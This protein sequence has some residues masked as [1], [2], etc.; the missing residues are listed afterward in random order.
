MAASPKVPSAEFLAL[1]EKYLAGEASPEELARWE[2][3][4]LAD[5]DALA[6]YVSL[7][8]IE[9][10][11]PKALERLEL[12]EPRPNVIPF[13]RRPAVAALAAC[14]A[15]GVL[16]GLTWIEASRH[17][18]PP[19]AISDVPARITS[20]VGVR[21][22]G[23]SQDKTERLRVASGEI[24]AGLLELTFDRGARLLIQGPARYTVLNDNALRLDYGRAVADVPKSAH[25]FLLSGPR[26]V[27]VD[28]GTRFAVEVSRDDSATT[29]GVLSGEV[30]LIAEGHEVHLYTD[31]A[32]RHSG[33]EIVSV[34]FDKSR[35]VTEAP[36]HDFS[37][38]LDGEVHDR[39]KT[40]VFDVSNLVHGP[41]DYRVV[42]RWLLGLDAIN[43]RQFRLVCDGVVV[44]K[45]D[46]A[47]SG[48]IG[49]TFGNAPLLH[50]P[51]SEYRPGRWMLELDAYAEG[52]SLIA[53]RPVSSSGVVSFEEGL[54]VSAESSKFVG[55]W[56]YSHNG[57][58][59]T[60][61]FLADGSA[62]FYGKGVLTPEF[63][64]ARWRVADG[65][66][67]LSFTD[68]RRLAETHM[69]RDDHTLVFL[70][71]PYRNAHRD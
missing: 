9:A 13:R 57:T 37:W 2:A 22:V 6:Y 45:A 54:S 52:A 58:D 47:R 71:R 42:V 18:A 63:D 11:T 33:H 34:P 53:G 49:R 26:D 14:L 40:F 59:C 46:A 62:R 69:L 19:A 48:D 61:E 4:C 64:G 31:Y 16:G 55:R 28:H 21:W 10:L 32:V 17:V 30:S 66:L 5:A 7:S 43:V 23:T 39:P 15:L 25:G 20:H 8:R 50:V 65:V 51:G 41:G 1:T 35:F 12:A 38:S 56:N 44:A 24:E 60:R 27:V 36:P 67:T 29:L 68:S 70:N 3:L